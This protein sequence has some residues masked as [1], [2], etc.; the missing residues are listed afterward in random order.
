MTP[1]DRADFTNALSAVYSL[2]RAELSDATLDLWWAALRQFE[3]KE[4]RVALT[5]CLTNPDSGQ[6]MPKPADVVRELGGTTGDAS[7]LAWAKVVGGFKQHGTH[8][9]VAFDDLIIHRVLVDM[10]G[11]Y[12]FGQQKTDDMPFIEKR[13]RDAYRAWRRKGELGDA[14]PHLAGMI[15]QVNGGRGFNNDIPKPKLIGDHVKALQ[16]SQGGTAKQPPLAL[17]VKK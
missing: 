7:M 15:E 10:G 2:Y 1:N 17:E 16:V 4:V 5:R 6:F 12:W 8:E 9:S 11:W 14:P 3:I 13:F